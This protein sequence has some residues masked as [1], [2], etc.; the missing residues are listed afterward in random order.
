MEQ[1][2][3]WDASIQS[4]SQEIL[5]LLWNPKYHFRLLKG[6]P[7]LPMLSQMHPVHNFPL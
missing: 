3:S 7:I 1:S 5:L 2:I 6:P 4:V